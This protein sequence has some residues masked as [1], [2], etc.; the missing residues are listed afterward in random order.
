MQVVVEVEV[1]ASDAQV[2]SHA[3]VLEFELSYQCSETGKTIVQKGSLQAAFTSDLKEAEEVNAVATAA[4]LQL[5]SGEL[6]LEVTALL[7]ANKRSEAVEKKKETIVM[8]ERAAELDPQGFAPIMLAAAKK[9]LKQLESKRSANK[10]KKA[11]QYGG[12]LQRRASISAMDQLHGYVVEED[13]SSEEEDNNNNKN[14]PS[15]NASY[16][17]SLDSDSDDDAKKQKPAARNRSPVR[18]RRLS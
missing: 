14:L 10:V 3:P 6:D 1:A 8:L 18:Q 17:L 11:V 12:Y 15:L 13:S 9:T 7:D 16:S 4:V 5:Q 2:G